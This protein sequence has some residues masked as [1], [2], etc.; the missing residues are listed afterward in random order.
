MR[1]AMPETQKFLSNVGDE[2]WFFVPDTGKDPK[3]TLKG[4]N[5]P[6]T[7]LSATQRTPG[8]EARDD[9]KGAKTPKLGPRFGVQVP[10]LE[11]EGVYTLTFDRDG[12]KTVYEITV[13]EPEPTLQG[14]DE[15]SV[16]Q[17]AMGVQAYA[18]RVRDWLDN[19]NKEG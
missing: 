10:R 14:S 9:G 11:Q 16:R 15:D 3:A 6:S 4:P 13:V 17:H 2:P 8:H 1:P 18:K 7:K 5:L 19:A 12:A